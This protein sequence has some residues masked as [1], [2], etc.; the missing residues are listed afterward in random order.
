MSDA[1][2]SRQERR[3]LA[4]PARSDRLPPRGHGAEAGERPPRSADFDDLHFLD[5][6]LSAAAIAGAARPGPQGVGAAVLA[7]VEATRR[8]VRT[9]TNL[10]MILLLAPLAA[11]AERNGPGR[12]RRPGPGRHDRRRRPA[13]LPGDPPGAPGGLGQAAEQDVADEPTVTLREAMALAADR[14]LVARQYA[15]ATARSSTRRFRPLKTALAGASRSETAIITSYLEPAVPPSRLADRPQGRAEACPGGVAMG[16]RGRSRPAGRPREGA[17][18][19]A[20]SST[21]ICEAK[22]TG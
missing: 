16:R 15:A 10:G 1:P 8:V 6:L 20:T 21:P 17:G 12:G 13:R 11:V 22:E 2:G 14:D 7:A 18:G 9:N 3:P 4:R 19:C 5:F